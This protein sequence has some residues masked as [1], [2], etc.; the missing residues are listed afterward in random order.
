VE[1][2]G[3]TFCVGRCAQV[4]QHFSS[5]S[6]SFLHGDSSFLLKKLI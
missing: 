1:V 5:I 3:K 4:F 2:D 6:F